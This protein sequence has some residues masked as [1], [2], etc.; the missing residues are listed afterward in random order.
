MLRAAE[1]LGLRVSVVE[2]GNEWYLQKPDY[3]ARFPAAGDYV[4]EA[5]RWRA[6]LLANW[7]SARVALVLA[8]SLVNGAAR[9]AG[10]NAGVF[11]ALAAAGVSS[12]VD[13]VMHEYHSS[14]VA[15]AGGCTLDAARV[16]AFLAS[17]AAIAANVTAAVAAL[18]PVVRAVFITE[19][20]L[21]PIDA[22][23][24]CRVYGT[25]AD[26]LWSALVALRLLAAPRVAIVDKQD[27]AGFVNSGQL[28]IEAD[29]FAISGSPDE[30]LTVAPFGQSAAGAALA[31]V[32]NAS[33][34]AASA[35]PLDLGAASPALVGFAF[36]AA[37]GGAAGARAAIVNPT[38]AAVHAPAS[39]LAGLAVSRAL[40]ASADAAASIDGKARGGGAVAYATAVVGAQGAALPAYS[41]TLLY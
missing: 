8:P 3:V 28:F 16:G 39:A 33:A 27:L 13:A 25:W 22:T 15:C 40:S 41:V 18:P 7:P 2:L 9:E 29:A 31:L 26:G 32:A 14:G 30:T 36:F 23:A 20:G 35:A 12:G 1:A 5:L 17:P 21:R 6:A 38:A 37:A 4:R 11:A 34:G 10:W 24:E 19:Y